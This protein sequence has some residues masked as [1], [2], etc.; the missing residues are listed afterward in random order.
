MSGM[1]VLL[2]LLSIVLFVTPIGAQTK[3]V[4][5]HGQVRFAQGGA[6]AEHVVVRLESYEGGGSISEAFT[7]SS[8]KFQF[9]SL[10]RRSHG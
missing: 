5:I 6:P 10:P 9:S 2:L 1:R 7:D 4:E 8:G 3:R